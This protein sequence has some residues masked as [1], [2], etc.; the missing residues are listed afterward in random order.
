M[1]DSLTLRVIAVVKSRCLRCG[2]ARR[3]L[4]D[5]NALCH[6]RGKLMNEVW[7][8]LLTSDKICSNS[9]TLRGTERPPEPHSI[10][11]TRADRC[12]CNCSF[13]PEV[14]PHIELNQLSLIDTE[15][16][17]RVDVGACPGLC[18]AALQNFQAIAHA[19]T[20]ATLESPALPRHVDYGSGWRCAG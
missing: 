17:R 12:W 20:V 11:N 8:A 9:P 5:K 1:M 6:C 3:T 18:C 4:E 2:S 10:H 19:P 15:T 13:L 7:R 16:G 14:W